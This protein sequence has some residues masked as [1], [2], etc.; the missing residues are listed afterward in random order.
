LRVR[1]RIGSETVQDSNTE[2]MIFPVAELIAYISQV[3]TLETGTVIATGTP[4]GVGMARTPPRW[5]KPGETVEVEIEKLGEL[6]N[7]IQKE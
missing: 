4:E 6:A 1:T 5:L 2:L 7:P 3:M